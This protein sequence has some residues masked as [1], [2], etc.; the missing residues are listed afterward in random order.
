MATTVN[1]GLTNLEANQ[2]NPEV[3]Y[4]SNLEMLDCI[5]QL[6]CVSASLTSP[7]TGSNGDAYIVASGATGAWSGKANNIA[8]YYNGWKFLVPKKGWRVFNIETSK[9]IYWN[10]T[11][12][13]DL[14]IATSFSNSGF[15]V[16]DAT[17]VTSKVKFN[18]D[19]IPTSTTIYIKVP[20][21]THI[22]CKQNLA[23][24]TMPTSSDSSAGGYSV[25]SLWINTTTDKGYICVDSTVGASVWKEVASATGAG[26][27]LGPASSVAN[28]LVRWADTTGDNIKG[29]SVILTDNKELYSYHKVVDEKVTNYTLTGTDSGK[30]IIVNSSSNY[31]ITLPQTSAE[32]IAN[33]FHCKVLRRG[34]GTVTFVIQGTDTIE[35]KSNY[36]AITPRYGVAEVVKIVNGSPNTWSLSGDLG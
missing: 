11:I 29:S 15:E 26:D 6:T 17:D 32:A 1:I 25:G 9:Y 19:D 22:L 33:G 24:T 3:T 28:T 10:S 36:V 12:W 14:P 31:S 4:N 18:V 2:F 13:T 8:Y 30:L 23:A 27:V 21:A 34:T 35:S 20:N 5:V 16:Y 7:P